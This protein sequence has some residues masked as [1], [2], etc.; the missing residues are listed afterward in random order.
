MKLEL[1]LHLVC[2][3]VFSAPIRF[4]NG[5]A[6]LSGESYKDYRQYWGIEETADCERVILAWKKLGKGVYTSN[7]CEMDGVECDSNSNVI[8]ISW[9]KKDFKGSL[10]E[11]LFQLKQLRVL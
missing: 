5:F 6:D 2:G 7:C 4:Y 8:S 11:E 1:L 3:I 10:P 9:I